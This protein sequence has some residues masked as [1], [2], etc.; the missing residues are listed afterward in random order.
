MLW[1]RKFTLR[2]IAVLIDNSVRNPF[3]RFCAVQMG[4]ILI[5][6]VLCWAWWDKLR[7][8]KWIAAEQLTDALNAKRFAD[9]RA[10]EAITAHNRHMESCNRVIEEQLS[11][12][13]RTSSSGLGSDLEKLRNDLAAARAETER[14]NAQIQDR[15]EKLAK[16]EA[17]LRT[18]ESKMSQAQE[19]PNSELIARL[20]RAEAQLSLQKG[21]RNSG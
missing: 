18:I 5:L 6:L 15:D 7:Q 21:R 8:G 20:E 2:R 11:G 17:R 16:Q 14:L 10:M 3:F 9:L 19:S 1:K 13:G 4:V 12:I